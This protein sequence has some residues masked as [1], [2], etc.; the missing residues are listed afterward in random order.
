MTRI[1]L[2]VGRGTHSRYAFLGPVAMTAFVASAAFVGMAVATGTAPRYKKPL[3]A[4]VMTVWSDA[5]VLLAPYAFCRK[6]QSKLQEFKA[7]HTLIVDIE[8]AE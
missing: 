5:E 4:V 1:E 7:A 8:F 6:V 2:R 3:A